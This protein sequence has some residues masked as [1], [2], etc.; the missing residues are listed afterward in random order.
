MFWVDM[1][2]LGFYAK[3]FFMQS[4]ETISVKELFLNYMRLFQSH[5]GDKKRTS[6]SQDFLRMKRGLG[7]VQKI[8]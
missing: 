4:Q 5:H 7:F 3:T 2:L 8:L 1:G 6:E